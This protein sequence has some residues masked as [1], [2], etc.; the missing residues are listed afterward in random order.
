MPGTLWI[1]TAPA[2]TPANSLHITTAKMVNYTSS[3]LGKAEMT[4]KMTLVASLLYQ[5]QRHLPPVITS[6][7]LGTVTSVVSSTP[8]YYQIY[9]PPSSS[10]KLVC[11]RIISHTTSC[12]SLL[13][14]GLITNHLPLWECD[15][16]SSD[17][18]NIRLHFP[19]VFVIT[20]S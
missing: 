18:R 5:G 13:H 15:H 4:Q 3:Y 9:H 16:Y 11:D 1:T 17:H 12:L 7:Q 20:S 2:T 10:H 6:Q 19:S 14:P 8:Q